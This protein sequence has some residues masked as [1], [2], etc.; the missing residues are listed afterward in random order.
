M[1]YTITESL[2]VEK[3]NLKIKELSESNINIRFDGFIGDWK[4]FTTTKI[5]LFDLEFEEG[6]IIRL[7]HFCLYGWI[8]RKRYKNNKILS[9]KEDTTKLIKE[10]IQY[11]NT[12]DKENLEFIG[13]KNDIYS[14][15]TSILL[16]KDNDKLI[17]I[18]YKEFYKKN[19][20][21]NKVKL[22]EQQ[23]INKIKN[24]I[25]SLQKPIKFIKFINKWKGSEKTIIELENE[26][27]G[28]TG[29][30]LYHSFINYGWSSS[31]EHGN[32]ISLSKEFTKDDAINSINTKLNSLR[33][34][35]RNIKFIK[36]KEGLWKGLHNTTLILFNE[37]FNE[38]KELS[39][40]SFIYN[41]IGWKCK[42]ELSDKNRWENET[43]CFEITRNILPNNNIIRWYKKMV[44]DFDGSSKTIEFDI[45]IPELSL[46][47]EYDGKQHYY[48]DSYFHKNLLSNFIIQVNRDHLVEDYCKENNIKLLRIPYLDYNRLEEVIRAFIIE[49][50]DITT[51]I[52]PKLLPALI[53]D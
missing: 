34:L 6:G 24:K 39:Y 9:F 15:K 17:E 33:Q 43:K 45:Y 27:T 35:G 37:D 36:F 25:S 29:H 19:H 8:C 53:Y 52:Q 10:R 47:I 42:Q 32:N 46:I 12:V 13:Y 48:F 16:I 7:Q 20:W 14:G 30:I 1:A 28:E 41:E 4:G 22:T 31:S 50:K 21:T 11:W 18:L 38:M 40:K 26:Q 49:G 2:A 23:G 51:H 5:K 3:I 44:K